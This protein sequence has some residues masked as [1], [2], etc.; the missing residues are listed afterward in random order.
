MTSGLRAVGMSLRDYLAGRA[1]QS[2]LENPQLLMSLML[3]E[4]LKGSLAQR[5]S[6]M[7][8]MYADSMVQTR[9][10]VPGKK[11]PT[12]VDVHAAEDDMRRLVL[13]AT[14]NEREECI[15]T[16]IELAHRRPDADIMSAIEALQ[17]RDDQTKH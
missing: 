3:E 10:R 17:S 5:V 15:R 4:S 13:E 16:C 12:V 7:A 14:Y 1:M 2:V 6:Q 9:G 11:G 8:Y